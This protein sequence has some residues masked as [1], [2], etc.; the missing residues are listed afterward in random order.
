MRSQTSR[1]VRAVVAGVVGFAAIPVVARAQK[2]DTSSAPI[3]V[4][5]LVLTGVDRAFRPDLAK[6]IATHATQCKNIV[7]TIF[8]LFSGGSAWNDRSFLDQKEFER[9]V[10]R[11]RGYYWMRGF[12]EATVDTSVVK[13]GGRGV[14]V[15]F[16][17][18]PNRPTLIGR[19]AVDFD[20][21]LIPEKRI[22]RDASL[23]A[24]TPFDIDRLDSMRVNYANEMWS[25]GYGDAMV[26][27]ATVVDDSVAYTAD[28]HLRLI[29]NHHTTVGP[30]VIT[31]LQ[32]LSRQ[33]VLNSISFHTGDPFRR[34]D[35]LAS[36]RTLYESNLFRSA[37]ITVVD[38]GTP[39]RRDSVKEVT[40]QVREANLRAIRV[41]TGFSNVDFLQTQAH[42][43]NYNLLG[44]A[45]RLD[46]DG[47]IGNLLARQLGGHAFFF[48]PTAF[49]AVGDSS[50]YRAPTWSVST[51][52]T[53][54]AFLGQPKDQLGV[55]A[56]AHRQSTPGIFIDQGYG[57]ALTFT[58]QVRV[59]VPVSLTY[60]FFG[61]QPR[62]RQ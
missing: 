14:I 40:I 26:D 54:P 51:G 5:R 20:S 53:Q 47:A 57:G 58:R 33:T 10:L 18:H 2:K 23:K 15:T 31:G 56:F 60:R 19:I 17:V 48:N 55:T 9:D 35:Q 44:N 37:R 27:T 1:W 49:S 7:V 50:D 28:L 43:T 39:A 8:C 12:R 52:L 11:I 21:T 41:G 61:D 45:R 42:F 24:G 3:E 4:R 29:P 38:T 30:I 46:I 36:Q 62:R 34:D 6:S 22:Q 25:R 16:T 59:H 32:H 13:D